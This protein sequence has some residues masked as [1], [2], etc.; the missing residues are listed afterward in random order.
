MNT[1]DTN[2]TDLENIWAVFDSLE[3]ELKI[4]IDIALANGDKQK[5]YELCRQ[6]NLLD[7]GLKYYSQLR[8]RMERK[9]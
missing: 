9:K 4:A 5:F 2:I 3:Y 7:E 6:A 8:K 1:R